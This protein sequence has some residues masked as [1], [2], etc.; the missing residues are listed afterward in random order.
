MSLV[1]I[2]DPFQSDGHHRGLYIS[3]FL[4][5]PR[6][7]QG[8][9]PTDLLIHLGWWTSKQSLRSPHRPSRHRF[10]EE[11]QDIGAVLLVQPGIVVAV[12]GLEIHLATSCMGACVLFFPSQDVKNPN[13]VTWIDAQD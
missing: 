4:G 13:R 5:L 9:W 7:S 2:V 12:Q 1:T 6:V 11:L 3:H 10:S 8:V